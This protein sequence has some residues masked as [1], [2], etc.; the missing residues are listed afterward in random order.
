MAWGAKINASPL[1]AITTEQ[2]F[3][4]TPTL[5]PRE[6]ARC[7]IQV[8]FPATPTDD[9][10]ISVY[11]WLDGTARS[12]IPMMVLVLDKELT[13]T[14]S[15][16]S[17][18][19]VYQFRIGMKRSGST[20]TLANA[21]LAFRKDGVARACT[22]LGQAAGPPIPRW[23]G[24]QHNWDRGTTG[25]WT[26]YRWGW[27]FTG[28]EGL[29]EAYLPPSGRS[30]P[31]GTMP[32]SPAGA[33]IPSACSGREWMRHW[34][35]IRSGGQPR[36]TAIARRPPHRSRRAEL[37]HRAPASGHDVEPTNGRRSASSSGRSGGAVGCAT[38]ASVASSA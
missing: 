34:T 4:H 21:D 22:R 19:G 38:G 28:S 33:P 37:P 36:A 15:I 5:D 12:A 32:W 8:Y 11:S 1:T 24:H 31:P 10:V 35:S 16:S 14:R 18:P 6:S 20:D 17:L 27:Q 2:F 7:H 30:G 9:A 23:A 29:G 26:I 13:P 3:D 25:S